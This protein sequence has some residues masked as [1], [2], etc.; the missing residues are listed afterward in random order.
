[1]LRGQTPTTQVR[2]TVDRPYRGGEMNF[3][4]VRQMSWLRWILGFG[5]WSVPPTSY[6]SRVFLFPLAKR[7]TYFLGKTALSDRFLCID[8]VCAMPR[9]RI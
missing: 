7:S 6:F 5:V 1:M 8:P 4:A 9:K 3:Y 2:G